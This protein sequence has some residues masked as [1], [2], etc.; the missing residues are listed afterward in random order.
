MGMFFVICDYFKITPEEFFDGDVNC[1][2]LMQEL[3]NNLKELSNK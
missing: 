1:T 2:V 3:I